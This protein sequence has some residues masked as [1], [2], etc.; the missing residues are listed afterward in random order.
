MPT[1]IEVSPIIDYINDHTDVSVE[2]T[3]EADSEYIG[4]EAVGILHSEDYLENR[5][6]DRHILKFKTK[7]SGE[8]LAQF[9]FAVF[10]SDRVA[11]FHWIS[12]EEPIRRKGVAR[13]IRKTVLDQI[14]YWVNYIYSNP[15]S[16]AG[17]NLAKSQGFVD[18]DDSVL[19][20]WVEYQT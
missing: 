4:W 16:P 14:P 18:I 7:R 2:C 11:Y 12:V 8:T 19:K 20:G 6:G 17:E 3:Y 10:E 5:Y 15:M 13:K 1:K 9:E